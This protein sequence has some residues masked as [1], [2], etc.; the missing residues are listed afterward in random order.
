MAP[1]AIKGSADMKIVEI[2]NAAAFSSSRPAEQ[3]E[4]APATFGRCTITNE[5]A[6]STNPE[7]PPRGERLRPRC[8]LRTAL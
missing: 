7:T 2:K 4:Q 8:A 5:T 3:T 6:V 1:I